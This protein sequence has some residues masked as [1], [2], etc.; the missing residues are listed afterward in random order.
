MLD[1]VSNENS[2]PLDG[3]ITLVNTTE[4]YWRVRTC[5]STG[6][7]GDWTTANFKY[8]VLS[9]LPTFSTPLAVP[10]PVEVNQDV[11]VSVNATHTAGIYAGLIEFDGS[12]H[13]MTADG[14]TFSFAWT[15]TSVGVIDYTIYIHSNVNTWASV[16]GSLNVTGSPTTTGTGTPVDMTMILIIVGAAAVVIVIIVII[17]KKK[18]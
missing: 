8:E 2:I 3:C 5:D 4:Y 11:T 7:W 18:K 16:S 1:F 17:M 13:S 6:V 15:P 9:S 14:D 10:D 12:N